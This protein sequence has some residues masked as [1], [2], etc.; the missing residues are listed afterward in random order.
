MVLN[1]NISISI[2]LIDNVYKLKE[3]KKKRKKKNQKEPKRN[4]KEPKKEPFL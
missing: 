3:R 2:F 4:E 1:C